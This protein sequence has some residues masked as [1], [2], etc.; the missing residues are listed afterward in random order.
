MADL[1]AAQR[2]YLRSQAHHL[3]PVV[4]VGRNGVTETVLDSV[5]R[6]LLAQELIKVRFNEHKDEKKALTQ[7]IAAATGAHVAGI[8]G[9]VAILY[10]EHPEPEKRVLRLPASE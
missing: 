10:R 7:D 6:A 3:H 2:K 9:H 5:D 4:L 1:T 8:I